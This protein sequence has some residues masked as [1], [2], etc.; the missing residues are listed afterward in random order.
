MTPRPSR[1]SRACAGAPPVSGLARQVACSRAEVSVDRQVSEPTPAERFLCES[2]GEIFAE[3][4]VGS[5]LWT[6]DYGQPGGRHVLNALEHYLPH[7]LR[8]VHSYWLNESLDGFQ[9]VVAT[10]TGERSLEMFGGAI[11]I[12]DQRWT[13]FE[14][15]LRL[16]TNEL[17]VAHLRCRIG[18]RGPERGGLDRQHRWRA[19]E[20]AICTFAAQRTDIEWAFAVEFGEA[21]ALD[22]PPP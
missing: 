6:C 2:L 18:A 16:A 4:E 7:L 5:P 8:Q 9:T 21:L 20:W 1:A 12:S 13:P 14:L 10:K 11:L 3:V 17:R 22:Q 15:S 19:R